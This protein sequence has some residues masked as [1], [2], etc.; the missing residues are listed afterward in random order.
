MPGYLGIESVAVIGAMDGLVA[1]AVMPKPS[2]QCRVYGHMG[3]VGNFLPCASRFT[4]CFQAQTGKSATSD[5]S[6]ID[7]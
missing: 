7:L 2:A 5:E 1:S 6:T 4:G 3:L